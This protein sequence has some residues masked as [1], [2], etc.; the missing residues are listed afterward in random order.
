M[1]W[2]S[3]VTI[4]LCLGNATATFKLRLASQ[5]DLSLFTSVVGRTQKSAYI[6]ANFS[7]SLDSTDAFITGNFH[8][9]LLRSLLS[10]SSLK[11]KMVS[12]V[13][14]VKLRN[15]VATTFDIWHHSVHYMDT[16]ARLTVIGCFLS[17]FSTTDFSRAATSISR[18]NSFTEIIDLKSSSRVGIDQT[19]NQLQ[20][21]F[22]GLPTLVLS[23]DKEGRLNKSIPWYFGG[24]KRRRKS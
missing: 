22:L 21:I 6:W 17:S 18:I 24:N 3:T 15:P 16:P 20:S 9:I 12:P 14:M 1:L 13:I 8:S 19:V 2:T 11:K 7:R 10:S 23:G 4:M 5:L